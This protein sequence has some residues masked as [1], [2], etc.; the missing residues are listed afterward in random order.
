MK[1][2]R[3]GAF[4][5]LA[6]TLIEVKGGIGRQYAVIAAEFGVDADPNAVDRAFPTAF[7]AAGRMAFA[8]PDAAEVASLEKGFW[9]NVVRLVFEEAGALAQFDSD[10]F[11]RYFERL[12]EYFATAEGWVVHPDVIPALERLKRAG[13]IVGLITNF[14]QRVFPLAEALGLGPYID[15]ITIPALAGAAKPDRAIFDYALARHGVRAS[16]AA[17]V[18]DSI[19]DDVD[20]AHAAGMRAVLLDRKGRFEGHSLPAKTT[21]IRSLDELG[22]ALSWDPPSGRFDTGRSR[23][24]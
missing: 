1:E 14:D 5:D 11:E 18:G 23:L 20:G 2:I 24:R 10:E 21:V 4:F 17:Q 15:S 12:Y 3:H 22:D 6:G 9:K 7:R 8:N 16:D 19:S 13:T